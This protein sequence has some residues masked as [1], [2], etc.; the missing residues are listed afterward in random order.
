MIR[1]AA[2][3]TDVELREAIMDIASERGEINR[4]RL[5][6]WISR[7]ASRIVDG[8]RFE[9]DT[10]S[11]SAEAWMVKSVSSV[12]DHPVEKNGEEHN[13]GVVTVRL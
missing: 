10:A 8:R 1:E 5:G 9:K 11:R 12:F 4:K 2:V 3:S 7:H 13:P 6:K